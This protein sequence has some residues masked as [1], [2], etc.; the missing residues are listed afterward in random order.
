[1]RTTIRAYELVVQQRVEEGLKYIQAD[2]W[3]SPAK[4]IDAAESERGE[5]IGSGVYW[6]TEKQMKRLILWR[7]QVVFKLKLMYKQAR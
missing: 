6:L 3:P 5:S 4:N 7:N 1:M 2:P